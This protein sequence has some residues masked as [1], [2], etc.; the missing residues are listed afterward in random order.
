MIDSKKFFQ[1]LHNNGV[2]F[3]AGVPDSL[4]KDFCAFVTDHV[5]SDKNIIT[6][7][8][9]AAVSMA[10]GYYLATGKPGLVYLQNSGLGNTVNP[11]MSLTDKEVYNI[12]LLM[13][14]GWRGEP[15]KKDEPQ[16]VKQG[17]ITIELLNVL[18]IPYSVID[19]TT[20]NAEGIVNIACQYMSEQNA[21][22]AVVVKDGTFEPY[23]LQKKTVTNYSF[24]REQ[25]LKIIIDHLQHD[26][27]IVSTTGKTSR[28]LYEYR[29]QLH[30]GHD[31]DFLTVG[32][33]GHA[34]QIALGIAIAK[35][36]RTVY[37]I[38]G[39]GAAIMHLGS[40]PI[41][42]CNHP[43]NYR[44]IVI[45]N[46]AHDSVGGQPTVGFKINFPQ[47]A[48]ASG[49]LRANSVESS[50]EI[51]RM[52]KEFNNVDGPTFLE[53]KVNKGARND[54]GRPTISPVDNKKHFMEFI[55]R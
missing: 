3:F 51:V 6:A 30:Q 26:D 35:R 15:G 50:E 1:S 48:I 17:K 4:L 2:T 13:I 16:H 31:K 24:N 25:A 11:L 21:P 22:Y 40:L 18:G 29:E 39:D 23:V 38:D 44:H 19:E 33:M 8:E 37:C 28:E 52:M 55:S 36:D 49:Y 45:N 32:A 43:K 42:G 14:I 41:I 7:N 20:E 10:A 9:G 12:P 34:S 46:G 5:E 27:I 53:V 54:L 47:I